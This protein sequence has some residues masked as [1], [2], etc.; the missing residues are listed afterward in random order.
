MGVAD[1]LLL[2]FLLFVRV[3]LLSFSLLQATTRR[4]NVAYNTGFNQTAHDYAFLFG[5]I[6]FQEAGGVT[7][8]SGYFAGH[9]VLFGLSILYR[10][11]W[12]ISF[13]VQLF[14]SGMIF[15]IKFWWSLFGPSS[16]GRGFISILSVPRKGMTHT[17]LRANVD[18]H[19]IRLLRA[20][21][22]VYSNY[23]VQGTT[24]TSANNLFLI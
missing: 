19:R 4:I 21:L 1:L 14:L 10:I 8:W 16:R 18:R 7:Q 15:A 3:S 9:L 17:K 6:L 11:M 12:L 23:Q 24:H 5:T 13:P 20:S 22:Y 2:P